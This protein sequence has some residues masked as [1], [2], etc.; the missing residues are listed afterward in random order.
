MKLFILF[1]I[2][3]QVLLAQTGTELLKKMQ[4]KFNSINDFTANFVQSNCNPSS[5]VLTGKILYKKKNKFVVELKYQTIISNGEVVWNYNHKQKQVI[6]SN[7]S[8]EP[9]SFSIERFIYNYPELCNIKLN[10][11]QPDNEFIE[12]IPKEGMLDFKKIKIWRDNNYLIRKLE[13]VDLEDQCY[14]FE[15]SNY[16][17]NQY[18]PDS[19]FS[20]NPPKGIRIVD[21]R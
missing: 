4:N 10:K 16:Q 11:E 20:F 1:I 15:F 6:I 12:L 18:L 14:L 17:L 2:Y 9:T 7:F 8:D 13:L 3:S 19:K 5:K 21:L